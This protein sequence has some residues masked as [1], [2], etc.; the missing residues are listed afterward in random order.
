MPSSALQSLLLRGHTSY[1]NVQGAGDLT[2][3]VAASEQWIVRGYQRKVAAALEARSIRSKLAHLQLQMEQS[4]TVT[5]GSTYGGSLRS[6]TGSRQ[7]LVG[8]QV[9]ASMVYKGEIDALR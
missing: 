7:V 2:N 5:M 9:P 8:Q 6:S 1:G 4:T 3:Y